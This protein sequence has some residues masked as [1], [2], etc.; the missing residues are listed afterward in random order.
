MSATAGAG[1]PSGGA[2]VRHAQRI[3]VIWAVALIIA[4]PLVIFALGPVIPP[5]HASQ[6]SSDQHQ[7]NV[8]L[9]A[10]A[11][12][13]MLLVWVYFGYAAVVFRNR[14]EVVV[15]GPPIEGNPRIQMIWLTATTV[16]VLF[17]AVLG[18]VDLFS[19]S[20]AGAGGGEG[21]SPLSKPP[22]GSNPLQV[23][24][25]GQQWLWTF[26]FP[27]YGGIETPALELPAGRYV[28]F[29]VTSLDVIHSFWAIELGAKAD[30]VP[31]NDNVAFVKPEQMKPFQIRCSELC[32][33]W[34]GEMTAKG[35]VV[36]PSEFDS[37]IAQQQATYG[38]VQK[39]LPPYSP[40]Y[41]P[42][43]LRRAS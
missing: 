33:L 26:R 17:L 18:T 34:H 3:A 14:G 28:E 5:G 19:G 8:T 20:A 2:D 35:R 30:A 29:H 39:Q 13:I 38:P 9:L 32:G 1:A 43:P 36:S 16:I 37:W 4:E 23:Q 6:Q 31:G 25:I 7:I 15:D 24:V 11:T 21:P 41:F 42:T 10:I 40:F 27:Q 22:S 12:P